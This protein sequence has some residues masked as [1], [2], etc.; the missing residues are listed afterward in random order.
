MSQLFFECLEAL[1]LSP[2]EGAAVEN[3]S[4]RIGDHHQHY[5]KNQVV[6][7]KYHIWD[8]I[9]RNLF[10]Q[11]QRLA[12]FYFLI[13]AIIQSIPGVSPV[14]PFLSMLPLLFVLGVSALKEAREDYF[15]HKQD[16]DVNN[17]KILVFDHHERQFRQ[18]MWKDVRVGDLVKV[19]DREFFAADIVIFKSSTKGSICYIETA[20]LDGET[21]LKVR[22]AN[23]D[24]EK[25]YPQDDNCTRFKDC[26]LECEP[27]NKNLYEFRGKITLQDSQTLS[28]DNKNVLLRGC[29]L[30]NTD[31]IV[32]VVVYAGHDTKLMQNTAKTKF[33]TSTIE[34]NLNGYILSIFF[35]LISLAIISGIL[36]GVFVENNKTEAWYLRFSSNQDAATYGAM[37]ILTYIILYNTLI[38]ISLYVSIEIVKVVQ[39]FIINSDLE[40][41]YPD[42]DTPAQARTSNLSD[43]LGE[44]QYIFSDKTG[45]LTRNIMEFKK[46]SIG[47]RTYGNLDPSPTSEYSFGDPYLEQDMLSNSVQAIKI[48]EYMLLM[49]VCHTVV[50]E[51]SKTDPD[52]IDAIVYQASSPDEGALVNAARYFKYKFKSRLPTSIVLNVFGVDEQWEILNTIEFN[53]DRKRMTVIAR[54]AEGALRIF[55]KGADTMMLPRYRAGQEAEIETLKAQLDHF[56]AEGLRTLCFGSKTI[57]EQE[58]AEWSQKFKIASSSLDDRDRQVEELANEIE[59][60]FDLVGAS[61]IE[62]KLQDGVPECIELLRRA[63]LK[64]WVLT[65]DKQETAINIGRSCRLIGDEMEVVIIN[66]KTAESTSQSLKTQYK[67]VTEKA[68]CVFCLVVDGFSLRFCL[69]QC[70][71][72]FLALSTLSKSVICCRVSPSQK[73]HVVKL[74]KDSQDAITLSIGDGANDVSMIKEAH[75]GVGISGQEGMQAVMSS[76]YAIAQF[77]FLSPLLM[78]HGRWS[79]LR[80]SQI[81]RY[82]FYKN[83]C[84]T[85]SSLWFSIYTGFSGQ[86]L[87]DSFYIAVFNVFFTSLPIMAIAVFDRDIPKSQMSKFP[88][89]YTY[90]Q[91]FERF[92][93]KSFWLWIFDGFIHSL[94]CFFFPLLVFYNRTSTLENGIGGGD[95]LWALGTTS[96]TCIILMVNLKV[97]FMNSTWTGWNWFFNIASVVSWFVFVLIYHSI[98]VVVLAELYGVFYKLAQM[99]AYWLTVFATPVLGCMIDF[100]V[101]SIYRFVHPKNTDIIREMVMVQRRNRKRGN[102]EVDERG[103]HSDDMPPPETNP[104]NIQMANFCQNPCPNDVVPL[105]SGS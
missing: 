57:S 82:S 44:I 58:Y 21:N 84:F 99:P 34:R 60:N 63:G 9:P 62:D 85:L 96:Y 87:L 86:T 32:G 68:S 13:I 31:W 67:N 26:H 43:E 27:P 55:C 48:R 8:F 20:N 29:Q 54:S 6:T 39:A 101:T 7:S 93:L 25:I 45:T 15:R 5:C 2:G 14:N 65:G 11:F 56:A 1:G 49:G 70:K 97:A 38:P 83:I 61:A 89:L 75:I 30:R 59:Q 102:R 100:G 72:E 16:N 98:D 42:T 90:R 76:D 78:I 33:K 92:D 94:L 10:E 36:G 52:N 51:L 47:G 81:V 41:Y 103:M 24:I 88:Q 79:Y 28:L 71:T 80:I 35:V 37:G 74:I 22:E 23:P 19:V 77:R 50:P 18:H 46:C 17:R 53:S 12:N 4:I 3:R 105:Q 95:S 73:A 66:E 64:I 104:R 40:M 69:D 91:K